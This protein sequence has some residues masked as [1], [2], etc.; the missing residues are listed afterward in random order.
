MM[1]CLKASMQLINTAQLTTPFIIGEKTMLYYSIVFFI[2]ALV[3]AV[4]GFGGIAGAATGIAKILF[5]V[6]L[7]IFLITLVLG[8]KP[9]I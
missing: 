2:V 8:R 7:V 1:R 5:F 3:A 6:F 9:K 4:L